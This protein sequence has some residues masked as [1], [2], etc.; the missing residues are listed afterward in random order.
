MN[1]YLIKIGKVWQAVRRDG[2]VRAVRRIVDALVQTLKPVGRGDVLFVTG[3][4][5]DSAL[6]RTRHVA[7]EL[8][9]HGFACSVTIQDNP[10][11]TKYA[12]R[13]SVFV[14][15]RTLFTP[16]V[17]ALITAIKAA[18]KTVIFDTDD[19]V[20]DPRYLQHMD[21]YKKMNVLER[22]LYDNGVG[23]EIVRD[24]YVEVATV[25]TTFLADALRTE[26][27]RAIVVPN[28][29]SDADV[30]NAAKGMRARA[31]CPNANDSVRMGYF[32]GTI[33][34]NK[35]FA[36]ITDVLMRLL[37][38]YPY[39]QLFLVGPLDV[40]SALVRQFRNRITQLPY[41][42]RPQHFANI[43][44]CDINLAPLEYGNPFCEAKSELKFFE[45]GLVKVPTVAVANQTYR[46]AIADGVDGFVAADAAEW[47][48]KLSRLITDANLRR[49]MG[50]KAYHT[51]MTRY[52]TV[53][54][55]N[56]EYYTYLRSK[57]TATAV[58]KDAV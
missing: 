9:K 34:H 7:E 45:A 58:A 36:T 31:Q 42:M 29:A 22:K 25:T 1:L 48:D 51:A 3:G 27:K 19:L 17:A 37:T 23:G 4:V 49:T 15:H 46:E 13:F 39:V 54:A 11:L 20:H 16:T 21:Y 2:P 5:G 33:S 50:E 24:P 18:G 35:D 6:Y 14:F 57:I 43:A 32:S 55:D 52:T 40:E 28:R 8:R 41:A 38:A 56:E 44:S 30:A 10:F 12:S 26:G 47:E 53:S